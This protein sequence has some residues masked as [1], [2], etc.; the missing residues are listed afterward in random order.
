MATSWTELYRAPTDTISSAIETLDKAKGHIC[1][2]VDGDKR[3]LGTVTDG[4]IRRGILRGLAL[5]S[6]ISDVMNDTPIVGHPELSNVQCKAKM[7]KR[8]IR[9][10]PIVDSEGY[11]IGLNL[12]DD[13]NT[14]SKP[15]LRKNTVVLM[16]GG[17]GT[18]LRPLTENMPK[19]L[20]QIG[21]KPLLERILESFIEHDFCNFVISV[22]YRSEMIKN[23]FGDGSKWN[24]SIEYL[25][26]SEK[27][28]TAGALSL[29]DAPDDLPVI[30]MNGDVLTQVNFDNLLAFH[31]EQKA[32]AMMCV[33]AY[34]FQVPYGVVHTNN[35]Q[36][37]AIEEKPTHK[38]F[39]NAG[40]YVLEPDVLSLIPKESYFDMPQLFELLIARDQETTV[41]PI[42]E[43][44]MDI[45]KMDDYQRANQD[46][47]DDLLVKGNS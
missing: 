8:Q 35:M 32:K 25:E 24:V 27:L 28:G 33:R 21:N 7:R 39:V 17:T 4:D 34:D 46:A 5:G 9:Q 18:R 31:A 1:L 37:T 43:Y 38:F 29:L 13:L 12:L 47:T 42:R 14:E 45:G 15:A 16:A 10:L 2:V 40:I 11:V 41:F 26:E 3:L 30:V 19:P 22:H 36:I 20:L 44:W 6:A 23:H